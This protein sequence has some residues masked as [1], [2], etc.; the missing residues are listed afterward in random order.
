MNR[1]NKSPLFPVCN[2]VCTLFLIILV[3]QAQATPLLDLG[4][5]G[6]FNGFVLGDMKASNSDIEGRLAV[7]GNLSLNNY[8][9]GQQLPNSNGTRDDLITGGTLDFNNG[10]VY[11]GNARSG[12]AANIGPTVGFYDTNPLVPN[13]GYLAGNPLDF[14]SIGAGLKEQSIEWSGLSSTGG[15]LI[16]AFNN[17]QLQGINTGLNVFSLSGDM[18]SIASSFWLD[19]PDD[20]WAL[21]NISGSVINMHDFAFF[22]TVN[23]SPQQLP[24][25]QPGVFR[26]DGHLTQKIVFNLFES[27]MLTM[28]AIGIKG[29]ILAPYADTSFYNGHIDGNLIVGSLSSPAGQNTGELHYYPVGGGIESI[30]S[31]SLFM[32][33]ILLLAALIQLNLWSKKK[34]HFERA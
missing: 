30:P 27:N 32:Q 7:G 1:R 31:L 11:N 17:I 21:V 20:S 14:A 33:L 26:Q 16:D 5:A 22:R 9:I 4:I 28:N 15:T 2:L 6:T 23:N 18:L 10:R 34:A 12:G 3:K 19:I 24:D 29:N 13:G 8:S 25:N